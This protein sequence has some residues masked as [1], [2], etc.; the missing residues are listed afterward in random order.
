MKEL[1]NSVAERAARGLARFAEPLPKEPSDPETVLSLL[2]ELGSP[3]TVGVAGPRFFGFVIGGTLPA[4][5]A[6][7][8]QPPVLARAG[9]DVERDGLF[10]APRWTLWWVTKC[11]SRS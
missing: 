2:D 8:W 9:W 11:I 3:A 5:L 1:L 4:G 6:A 7:N 10:R